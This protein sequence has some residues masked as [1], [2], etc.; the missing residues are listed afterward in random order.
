[1]V[2]FSPLTRNHL[3]PWLEGGGKNF[4]TET[5][6]QETFFNCTLTRRLDSLPLPWLF[7]NVTASSCSPFP[8]WLVKH[9]RWL[10]LG[11]P[12]F[13]GECQVSPPK[14]MAGGPAILDAP[15]STNSHPKKTRF[16]TSD[17]GIHHIY[18]MTWESTF[19]LTHCIHV[20]YIYLHLV[21]FYVKC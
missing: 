16:E 2:K 20:W 9:I 12:C 19:V 5:K 1:M 4:G 15:E 6:I 7:G 3:P 10:A 13:Y 8:T 11:H 18:G 21:D 14:K 17:S